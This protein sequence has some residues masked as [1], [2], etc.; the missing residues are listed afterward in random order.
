VGNPAG[1]AFISYVREDAHHV[2]QLQRD[3]EAAGISVWRDTADLWPGED[4]RA[5]IRRA[6]TDNALVFIACFSSQSAAR[7]TSY[8]YEELTLAI[9]QLRRRRPDVPWLIPVRFDDCP[10]PDLDLG[11]GRTLNSIQRAD[12]FGDRRE[13]QMTRLLAIVQR[14]LGQPLSSQDEGAERA[15][16]ASD[17]TS[18][19]PSP[20]DPVPEQPE[21]TTDLMDHH[22]QQASSGQQA[23]SVDSSAHPVATVVSNRWQLTTDGGQV[24]VLM[25]LRDNSMSHPGYA[26]LSVAGNPPPSMRIGAVVPC[27]P[28]GPTPPTS[29][30]RAGFLSFLY[31]QPV[32][33]VLAELTTVNPDDG[34]TPWDG[35]GRFNFGA[36]LGSGDEASPVA[37]A[38]LLL[39]QADTLPIGYDPRSAV[40]ILHVYPRTP[41]GDPAPA[42]DLASWRNRFVRA[43]MIPGALAAFLIQDL[44]L[45]TT[46][47]QPAQ[48]GVYLDAPHSMTELVDTEDLKFLPGSPASSWFMGWAISSPD[49][50]QAPDLAREWLVQMCDSTLHVD[51]YEPYLGDLANL[52][53]TPADTG[54]PASQALTD[55]N[56]SPLTAEIAVRRLKQA[57]PAPTRR[58]EVSDL[59][60]GEI[61]RL[62]ARIADTARHPLG[63]VPFA[64][65]RTAYEEETAVSACLLATGVFHGDEMHGPIWIRSLR[66]LI[67]ARRPITG[68]SFNDRTEAMRHYPALL[69]LWAMGIAV[70]VADRENLL[71]RFLIEPTWTPIF[72]KP[73]PQPAVRCLN[74]NR[75]VVADDAAG[76]RRWLYPQSHHMRTVSR[77]TLRQIE[78]DDDTYQEAC[79]RLEYLASLIVM[80]TDGPNGL[81]WVGEF[82]TRD[83]PHDQALKLKGLLDGGAFGSDPERAKSAGQALN[84]WITQHPTF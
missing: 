42:A 36:V 49:G 16:A 54:P 64:D 39:P 82:M 71:A 25:R 63:G 50:Q 1:H 9:E 28:L 13:A 7:V 19:T 67:S 5:K 3:L 69:C 48:T 56:A 10:V 47:D 73:E 45:T 43:L 51:A 17:I 38:R 4:W 66:R 84:T 75:I 31:R 57:L 72:G 74:P 8:Q 83:R 15:S 2:D 18:G 33:D 35:H 78:P 60:D 23:S 77:D 30:I 79:D 20:H 41:A 53:Q 55:Q 14:L 81:P 12:L 44:G 6:I 37:W 70:I 59:V 21:A 22:V 61:Q 52:R 32:N 46:G 11:P 80:D 26:G 40:F 65:Q 29:S 58:I 27:E 76:G 24:P 62:A 68:G 34:W